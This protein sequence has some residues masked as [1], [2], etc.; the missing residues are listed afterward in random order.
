MCG[1]KEENLYPEDAW[2]ILHL[3]NIDLNWFSNQ[4]VLN[5]VTTTGMKTT[6]IA[7]GRIMTLVT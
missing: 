4:E 2:H 6:V 5:V 3:N 7:S 1:E